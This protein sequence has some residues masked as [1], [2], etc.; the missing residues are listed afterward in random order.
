MIYTV[1]RKRK[2]NERNYRWFTRYSVMESINLSRQ[3]LPFA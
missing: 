2:V 3:L 1:L